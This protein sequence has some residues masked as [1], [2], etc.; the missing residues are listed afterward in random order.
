MIF[1]LNLP[2]PKTLNVEAAIS[3]RCSASQFMEPR[4]D[5]PQL[6]KKEEPSNSESPQLVCGV[7]KTLVEDFLILILKNYKR[8]DEATAFLEN[9]AGVSNVHAF[10]NVRDVLSHLATMLDPNTPPE[11]KRDQLNNAEEHLRRAVLEPYEVAFGKLIQQFQTIYD[12]Y[13]K[14]VVP[15][16]DKYV[17][18]NS[19]PNMVSVN[20]RLRGIHDLY[21]SGRKAKGR[22]LWTPEWEKGVASFIEAYDKLVTLKSELEDYYYKYERL[23]RDEGQARKIESLKKQLEAESW[24][25]RWFHIGGYVIGI[26]GIILAIIFF[27]YPNFAQTIKYYFKMI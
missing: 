20:A 24:R 25:S 14:H 3:T 22:N 18:L 19:A 7:D 10:T 27:L 12:D 23:E 16:T 2:L 5:Q 26:I 8:A 1:W 6:A 15:A 21:V 17:P 13:I 4:L 11:K 9:R